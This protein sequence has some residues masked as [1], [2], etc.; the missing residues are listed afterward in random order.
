MR[1]ALKSTKEISPSMY[2]VGQSCRSV[3][4]QQV[5]DEIPRIPERTT[6]IDHEDSIAYLDIEID[7]RSYAPWYRL[8][9]L[10]R[11]QERATVTFDA[12]WMPILALEAWHTAMQHE[13]QEM[14]DRVDTL[15]QERS[16]REQ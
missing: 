6:W 10:E 8:R 7:P 2:E 9:S 12:L 4:D 16:R 5:A 11:E 1:R 13:L 15:E 3:P 14:R